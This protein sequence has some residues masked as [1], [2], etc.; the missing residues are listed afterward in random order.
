MFRFTTGRAIPHTQTIMQLS[1]Q[2]SVTR[3]VPPPPICLKKPKSFSNVGS[4]P[5]VGAVPVAPVS[6]AAVPPPPKQSCPDYRPWAICTGTRC[7]MPNSFAGSLLWL[8]SYMEEEQEAEQ[9]SRYAPA[10]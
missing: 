2:G 4:K 8:P 6:V 10:G 7:D 5:P 3:R 9:E 1:R